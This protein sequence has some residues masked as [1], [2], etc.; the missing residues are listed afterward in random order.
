MLRRSLSRYG[1][2]KD[3]FTNHYA[4]N[5]WKS[6]E[7]ASGMGSTVESTKG[8]RDEIAALLVRLNVKS[9]LDAPC[10]DYNWFRLVPRA[11]GVTYTGGDIVDAIVAENN[12]KYA[13]GHTRFVQMD[14]I[15]DALP[16]ADLWLCRDGMIHFS[17]RCILSTLEN[18][19]R[20]NIRYLLTTT[21][22]Q[23]KLNADIPT[24][25][26]RLLN[27]ERP[28]F[29]LCKPICYIDDNIDGHPTRKLALWEAR[30]LKR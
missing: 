3:V 26:F 9:M 20:S 12:R 28:P 21:Y 23:A 10:G 1:T 15:S 5:F 17:D 6:N 4:R 29:S 18:L 13:D 22:P 11:D 27:L 25:G 2:A 24:G 7:S 14:I 19:R 30:S 8:I 16:D